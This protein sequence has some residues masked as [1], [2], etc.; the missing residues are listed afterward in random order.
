M[1]KKN[2]SQNILS[3]SSV[4]M[5]SDTDDG[6][7]I[8]AEAGRL[9]FD[10]LELHHSLKV[11]TVKQILDEKKKGS[12]KISSLHNHCPAVQS[13][14]FGRPRAEPYSLC[15]LGAH[16]RRSAIKHTMKTI[17]FAQRFEASAVV[18]HCGWIDM[19]KT[20]SVLSQM[21]REN[22]RDTT[23]YLQLKADFLR[24]R[25]KRSGRHLDQLLRSLD[26]LNKEAVEAGIK[27]GIEN[28]YFP[29]E[30]PD[31]DE[32]GK[33]QDRFEGGNIFY[34]HDVGHA[35]HSEELLIAKHRD[36]LERYKQKLIG[37]HIHDIWGLD[38][39]KVPLTGRF[40]FKTILPY[41]GLDII[42]VL[43]ISVKATEEELARG[44]DYIRNL[45]G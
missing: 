44:I 33:I 2:N 25:E 26:V 41:I 38:D 5:G 13:L 1:S 36:Y 30:L 16:E 19:E 40:N 27:L 24:K 23:R 21:Y 32:I 18:L 42:K 11:V 6:H 3:L 20:G 4:W 9:G 37:V 8:V 10:Y 29:W 28:R 45:F 31:F 14:K 22:L 12:I 34:W 15:S 17:A 43:E 39:H 35:Q 7:E